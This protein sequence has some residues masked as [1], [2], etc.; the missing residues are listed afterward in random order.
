MRLFRV[1]I[2]R[3]DHNFLGNY[4]PWRQKLPGNQDFEVLISRY[5]GCYFWL[6]FMVSDGDY[7]NFRFIIDYDSNLEIKNKGKTFCVY[8]SNSRLYFVVSFLDFFC[9]LKLKQNW[10]AIKISYYWLFTKIR[11]FYEHRIFY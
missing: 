1:L 4:D 10:S 3:S 9:V 7:M 11:R 8:H 6:C 2:Y 5:T